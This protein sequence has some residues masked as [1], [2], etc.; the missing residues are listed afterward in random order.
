MIFLQL[1]MGLGSTVHLD[2]AV[3]VTASVMEYVDHRI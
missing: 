1:G 3:P 2:K